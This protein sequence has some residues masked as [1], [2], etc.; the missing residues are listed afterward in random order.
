MVDKT[1]S[2]SVGTHDGTFHAD[3]VTAC[4][5]LLLFDLV[6]EDKIFRTRDPKELS[7]CEYV[8]DVGGI[9]DPSQKLFDHH[10][11]EYQGPLSSAGMILLYLKEIKLIPSKE[12]DLL[13]KHMMIGVDAHDNGKDIVPPG[14][15]TYSNIISSFTPVSHEATSE[16]QDANFHQALQFA[17]EHL[18]RLLERHRYIQSC[19]MIVAN[20]MENKD[21]CLFF[22]KSIP[23]L[24]AFFELGGLNHPAKFLIMPAGDH[25]KL[26]GIPPSLE[27]RMNVRQP[28]PKDWA[29]LL[30]QDLKNASGIKGAVFCHK[31]R[32]VSVWETKED[33]IKALEY[34]LETSKKEK[35]K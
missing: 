34:T 17:K 15:C 13:N 19:K 9:Y 4:A 5:L 33:A 12:Y 6:D 20:V 26:R 24:E 22:D 28:L 31:G 2:R 10:Q 32:F 25:W 27:D 23:W 14:V 29:G 16:E 7:K 11:V 21:D 35:S 3:E 1:I 30:D 8:C 18:N